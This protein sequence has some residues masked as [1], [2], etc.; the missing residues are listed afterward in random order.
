VIKVGLSDQMMPSGRAVAQRI[1]AA[2]GITDVGSSPPGAVGYFK[3]WANTH[4]K[5]LQHLAIIA[6]Y[7]NEHLD[8]IREHNC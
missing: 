2:L 5:V 6:P 8:E 1:K 4:L 7:I 3:G